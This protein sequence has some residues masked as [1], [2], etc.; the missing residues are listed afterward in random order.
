M[1][2]SL[3]RIVTTILAVATVGST[4]V[5]FTGCGEKSD[6]EKVKDALNDFAAGAM[7]DLS[8]MNDLGELSLPETEPQKETVELNLLDKIIS[9]KLYTVKYYDESYNN[10]FYIRLN[11]T[12]DIDGYTVELSAKK[13]EYDSGWQ[14]WD[15]KKSGEKLASFDMTRDTKATTEISNNKIVVSIGE[16]T[17]FSG[18]N[19]EVEFEFTEKSRE[20]IEIDVPAELTEAE[21]KQHID[22]LKEAASVEFKKDNMYSAY[23]TPNLDGVYYFPG[24]AA[25]ARVIFVYSVNYFNQDCIVYVESDRP[26][27]LGG[28]LDFFSID[29]DF[30]GSKSDIEHGYAARAIDLTQGTKIG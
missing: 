15:I 20:N 9:G 4:A 2:K 11:D 12:I 23:K 26:F 28:E 1:K 14:E 5:L 19:S 17:P 6:E 24:D 22:E 8:A 3:K 18:D 25:N 7:N 30:I 13:E 16:G 29:S 10:G 21:C 27:I